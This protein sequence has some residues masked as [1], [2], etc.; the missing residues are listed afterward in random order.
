VLLSRP[1]GGPCEYQSQQFQTIDS[2]MAWSYAARRDPPR[3]GCTSH[4]NCANCLRY[5][6]KWRAGIV[7]HLDRGGGQDALFDE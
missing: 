2:S 4:K 3:P 1:I 7:A 5:A 6:A